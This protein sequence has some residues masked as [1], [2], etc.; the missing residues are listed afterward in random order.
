MGEGEKLER[1][2][3]LV[4]VRP[5][6]QAMGAR[7]RPAAEWAAAGAVF[8]G[9]VDEEGPGRWRHAPSLGES[10]QM[11]VSGTD[12][13]CR[14]TAFRHVGIFPEQ[15]VHWDWAAERIAAARRPLR[16]LNLFGYTGLASLLAA[17]AGAEVTHVDA[18]KKAIAWARENQLLSG[19]DSAP[20]RWICDDAVKFCERE[21]RRGSVYDGIFLDPPKFGRGPDGEVWNLFDDLPHMLDLCRSL[22]SPDPSFVILTAYSIRASFLAGHELMGD[23]FGDLPGRLESGELVLRETLADGGTGR[24]LS[25]SMFTRWS[26]P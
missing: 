17:K 8:T 10:W 20:I 7:R 4:T 18:S 1:Y 26:A 2:G 19:L 14:L 23:L 11:S 3:D 9:D 15:K 25:T 12:F 16:V 13:L 6:P 24:A 22:L 5:E 21:I